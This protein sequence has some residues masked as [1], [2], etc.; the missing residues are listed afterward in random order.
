MDLEQVQKHPFFPWIGVF[1]VDLSHP[2]GSIQ[3]LRY[4]LDSFRR[5]RASLFLYPEGELKHPLADPLAHPFKPGLEWLI[6][7][8]HEAGLPLDVVPMTIHM[9]TMHSQRQECVIQVGSAIERPESL[10][11]NELE[12]I[13]EQQLAA[14]I[15][16]G[17]P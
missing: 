17:H 9:H 15:K 11:T 6:R 4:A 13:L 7:Q 8:A 5:P 12:E 3:S 16:S 2:K 14:D 1:S 10:S